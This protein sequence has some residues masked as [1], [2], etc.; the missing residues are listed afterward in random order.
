M[1]SSTGA[2]I[3]CLVADFF[4]VPQI[5]TTGEQRQA[6]DEVL[7]VRRNGAGEVAGHHHGI[8]PEAR[9]GPEAHELERQVKIRVD[10]EDHRAQHSSPR[11]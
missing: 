10:V 8:L 5:L 4:A 11:T 7:A 9:L 2:D 3:V 1:K 6:A